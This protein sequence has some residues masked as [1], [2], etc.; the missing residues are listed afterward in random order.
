MIRPER[1][2]VSAATADNQLVGKTVGMTYIGQRTEIQ[3]ETPV[4][5]LMVVQLGQAGEARSLSWQ[6]KDCIIVPSPGPE[7]RS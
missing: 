5:R 4:G 6:A 2:Q 1:I 3:V 7:A